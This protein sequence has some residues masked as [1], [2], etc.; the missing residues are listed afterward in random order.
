M[1]GASSAAGGV[2]WRT[3]GKCVQVALVHRARYDDW[4]FPKGKLR[5]AEPV[6]GSA[7]REVTKETGTRPVIGPR[8]P[9]QRYQTA[10]GLK[11][12]DYWAMCCRQAAPPPEVGEVDRLEWFAPRD[13]RQRL[14]Y[15]AGTELV[16]A[17]EAVAVL[18]SSAVLIVRHGSAGDPELWDGDD[19]LRPL[20]EK[21]R[22]QAEALR[23]ALRAFAPTRLLSAGPARCVGTLAPL[24]DDLGLEI[25]PA[26]AMSETAYARA[27]EAALRWTMELAHAGTTVAVC[28][29]GVVVPSLVTAISEA[30]G[31][32][33]GPVAAKKGSVWALWFAAGKLVAA[34]YYPSLLGWPALLERPPGDK[35]ATERR[36]GAAADMP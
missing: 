36:R 31:R 19:D 5:K 20:D 27:P 2:V 30:S 7:Y 16:D 3:D 1:T 13:A 22:R 33:L 4:S 11:E 21:G 6:L 14:S 32:D 17:L 18:V 26:P 24:A 35:P 23:H 9:T 28:S 15:K 10:Q 25:G 29:Q 12:V 34:D 8:L